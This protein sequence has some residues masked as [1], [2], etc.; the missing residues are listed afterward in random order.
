[1]ANKQ[2]KAPYY[3]YLLECADKT[4]YIGTTNDLDKRVNAHN[5]EKTGARYTKSRRPVKLKYF[6]TLKNKSLA[7]RR[8]FALKKLTRTQK[9][10]LVKS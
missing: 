1:M 8:E 4:F 2:K 10:L 3:V 7:L 5:F 6:E 9:L